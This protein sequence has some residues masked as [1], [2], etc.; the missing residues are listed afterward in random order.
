MYYDLLA[1]FSAIV[2]TLSDRL[3]HRRVVVPTIALFILTL[4][5]LGG[6]FGWISGIFIVAVFLL[7]LLWLAANYVRRTSDRSAG[8]N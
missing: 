1:R 3:L 6:D 4:P 2:G 8:P 7:F 5:L